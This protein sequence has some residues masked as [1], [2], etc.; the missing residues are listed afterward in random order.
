MHGDATEPTKELTHL[1][2]HPEYPTKRVLIGELD[3]LFFSKRSD[4]NY[5]LAKIDFSGV[6]DDHL[7]QSE[8]S[9]AGAVGTVEIGDQESVRNDFDAQMMARHRLIGD[10]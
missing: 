6:V 3:F 2:A 1:G 10:Y 7:L 4:P 5:G 8:S 9:D